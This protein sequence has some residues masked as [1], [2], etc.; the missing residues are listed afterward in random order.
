MASIYQL[1]PTF[2]NLLRP[3]VRFM[4]KAGITANQ[5]TFGAFLLSALGGAAIALR[6]SATWP[7][8]CLPAVLFVRMALNAVDGMLAREFAMKSRLGAI[9]NEMGDVASDSALYLPLAL[10]PGVPAA[11]IVV[12]VALAIMVEMMGVVA[13]QIGA[14]RRYDGPFGKSDR[15]FAFGALALALGSGLKPGA[16]LPGLL[17]ALAALSIWTLINRARKALAVEAA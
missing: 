3:L 6:P 14:D 8:F 10:V 11:W 13:I 5:V 1:K 2:Q 16:W 15:A 9:L 12:G 4:A 17:A 7:L